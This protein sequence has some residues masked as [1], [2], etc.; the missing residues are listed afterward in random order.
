MIVSACVLLLIVPLA[1]PPLLAGTVPCP[2]AGIVSVGFL[3]NLI[4]PAAFACPGTSHAAIFINGNSGFTAANGV[5][6]GT[7][8][9]SDPYIISGWSINST[10]TGVCVEVENTSAY[11]VIQ[12]DHVD[13]I[14]YG[15]TGVVFVGVSNARIESSSVSGDGYG[16]RIG[17]ST[18]VV[19]S[20]NTFAGGNYAAVYITG[21]TSLSVL[22]NGITDLSYSGI[23]V[24]GCQNVTYSG[25][26][27]RSYDGSAFS[28]SSNVTITNNVESASYTQ[29]VI[30]IERSRNFTVSGNIVQGGISYAI[31][32]RTS[33]SSVISNNRVTGGGVNGYSNFDQG[34]VLESSNNNQVFENNVTLEAIGIRVSSSTGNRVYHDNLV[35]NTIQAEDDRPG[36][37]SWDNGY[38]S[39]GNYW[40]DYKGVD[41]CSGP[42]QNICPSSDGIG[43]TPY[44][45]TSGQD[46]YPLMKPFTPDPPT[47]APAAGGGGARPPVLI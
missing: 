21:T 1:P 38:P 45:F 9:A 41:N 36:Q 27:D 3:L 34:I 8:T 31:W 15:Y 13:C 26:N 14:G 22:G 10:S 47:A 33:N 19:L 35:N 4:V 39:G 37:N 5:V 17:S 42:Q 32:F 18:N 29:G 2:N 25:N 23:S 24:S 12:N 30:F 16:L 44:T 43:D 46:N 6:G 20:G 28:D 7:G 40:S 11:F